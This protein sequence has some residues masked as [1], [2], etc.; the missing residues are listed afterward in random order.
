MFDLYPPDYDFLEF[1]FNIYNINYYL[2]YY[3]TAY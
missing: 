3:F 1:Y 2:F